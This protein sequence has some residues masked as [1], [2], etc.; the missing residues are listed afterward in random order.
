MMSRIVYFSQIYKIIASQLSNKMNASSKMI[1]AAQ[2]SLNY[3]T[4]VL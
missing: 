1:K 3:E 2:K 4:L